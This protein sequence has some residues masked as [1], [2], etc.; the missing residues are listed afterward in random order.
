V[1]YYVCPI[2]GTGAEDDG[3][4]PLIADLVEGTWSACISSVTEQGHRDRGKPR[5]P[6]ALVACETDDWSAVEAD[7]RCVRVADDELGEPLPEPTK[8]RLRSDRV[9]TT[10]ERAAI[11]SRRDAVER[12]LQQHYPEQTVDVFERIGQQMRRSR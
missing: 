4:R 7:A 9:I 8:E 12:L 5:L 11:V 10:Q 2:V 1:R 6:W 3:F